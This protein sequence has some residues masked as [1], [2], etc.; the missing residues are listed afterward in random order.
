V[1]W[2][3]RGRDVPTAAVTTAAASSYTATAVLSVLQAAKLGLACLQL[4]S[5]LVCGHTP[6]PKASSRYRFGFH[7]KKIKK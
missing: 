6:T 5:S 3:R 4:P 2:Q 7:A 1:W